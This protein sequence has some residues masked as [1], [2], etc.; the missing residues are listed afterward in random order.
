MIKELILWPWRVISFAL[1]IGHTFFCSVGGYFAAF[2]DRS[3]DTTMRWAAR[4]WGAGVLALAL[5][6]VKTF[7]LEKLDPRQNYIF[8]PNHVSFMDVPVVVSKIPYN[9]R[10][11][12]KGLFFKIPFYGQA[13]RRS[14]NIKMYRDNPR[15]D[16]KQLGLAAARLNMGNSV[17]V[18]PEGTRSR[19]GQL[20]PLKKA[21]FSLPLKSGCPVVPVVIKGS[22]D[23]MPP[24]S[25]RISPGTIEVHFL[26]PIDSKRYQKNE[27]DRFADDV[28]RLMAR[29]MEMPKQTVRQAQN[30]PLAP[31]Q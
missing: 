22:Y 3:G 20:Q 11:V 18:F 8:M 25:I 7:G 5:I 26:D 14:G 28:Y 6:R 21:L 13:M 16:L 10:I 1:M 29:E 19:N 15:Q 9:V 17:V 23:T 2:I 24:D 31:L 12:A 4:V 27:R 30:R